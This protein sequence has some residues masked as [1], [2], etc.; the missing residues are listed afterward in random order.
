MLDPAAMFA[1]LA[2][3]VSAICG[4]PFFTGTISTQQDVEYDAGGDVIPGSG[5]VLE[6]SCDV[7]IDVADYRMR[8][9][10]GWVEGTMACIILAATL[11]GA[12]DTDATVSIDAGPYANTM[13]QVSGIGRD[14]LGTHWIGK[15]V[16]A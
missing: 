13:W 11:D 9:A 3:G 16:E 15:A 4:G 14:T 5:G 2:R 6:R 7:Q 10:Q 1:Q 8:Q 12:I